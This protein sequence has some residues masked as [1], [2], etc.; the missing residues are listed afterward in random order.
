MNQCLL[1]QTRHLHEPPAVSHVSLTLFP[2]HSGM[3]RTRCVVAACG[4]SYSLAR[5]RSPS[6]KV[7][8]L[9]LTDLAD[10]ES[11]MDIQ[12]VASTS[13]PPP[14]AA[15]ADVDENVASSRVTEGLLSI[16]A[17][18]VLAYITL[19]PPP[20]TISVAPQSDAPS[21]VTSDSGET[22]TR[23]VARLHQ[24]CQHTFGN[25]DALK[26][27]FEDDPAGQGA[28]HVFGATP[29]HSIHDQGK[30]CA[31]TITR[32]NGEARTFASLAAHTRKYDAK[33]SA[34]TLAIQSGALDFILGSNPS[35]TLTSLPNGDEDIPLD[36]DESVKA[37]E[38]CC[39]DW[40]GGKVKP[41][42]LPINEPKFGRSTSLPSYTDLVALIA[43]VMTEQGYALRIRIGSHRSRVYSVDT[44][45]DSSAEAKKACA[46]AALA[47]GVI[48]YIQTWTSGLPE[49]TAEEMATT[50]ISL[51]E[52]FDSLPQPFPEPVAGKTAYDINGPAWLNTTIQAARGC[53]LAPNFVW[54]VDPRSG[55]AYLS[56]VFRSHTLTCC[57]PQCM[58][59]CCVS[60][61]PARSSPTSLT[62]VS[63]RGRKPRQPCAC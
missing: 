49:P 26:F 3:S 35:S 31:L 8:G 59:A 6:L 43:I 56:D 46:E 50:A 45:H 42:W 62:H 32:P 21:S 30:R 20:P 47:D 14:I 5:F 16:G 13:T 17:L 27:V 11:L 36:M 25:T 22:I 23:A 48:A 44:V 7:P 60:N 39:L 53:K 12:P 9:T 18:P 52:F 34:C 1:V 63:P 19:P 58:A 54:T 29:A 57:L 41:F 33:A 37:I 2:C 51:Q 55:C 24:A 10:I 15:L 28:W 4:H 40:T 38:Q 61:V